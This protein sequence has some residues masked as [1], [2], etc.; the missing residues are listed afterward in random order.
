MK[1]FSH[2]LYNLG[3]FA[4][5]ILL[6]LTAFLLWNKRN[7]G[8]FYFLGYFM[9]SILNS[10]LK[11]I[12]QQPRPSENIEKFNAMMKHGK[13]DIFKNQGVPFDIFGMPSGHAQ[14]CLYSTTFMFLVLRRIDL[15]LLYLFLSGIAIWQ[16]VQYKFHT[17]FQTI[18][19]SIFGIIFGYGL[20][21]LASQNIKGL[22]RAKKDNY[23]PI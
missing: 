1:Y 9:N 17:P 7:M 5:R 18:V 19:G 11:G 21:Y 3:E 16:R 22:I 8:F 2:F 13:L 23:G 6:F 20:F 15:L 10:V 12:F 4:P 14:S